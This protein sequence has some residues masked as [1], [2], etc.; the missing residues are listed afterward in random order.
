MSL[1]KE[2]KLKQ[3]YKL[4]PEGVVVPSAWF[5]ANRYSSQ[6]LYKY[7]KNGWLSKV[8]TGAYARSASVLEWQGAILGLQKLVQLPFY[9]GGVTALNIEGYA[10]YLPIGREKSISLYGK[11][12]PPAWVKSLESPIFT[13]HKKP[14]F[15]MLGLKKYDTKIR[16]WQIEISSAERAILELLYE[17]GDK[18]VSFQFTAEIFEGLNTLSPRLLNE[19]LLNC[20]NRKIKR[21]FLFFANYYNFPWVKHLSKEISLGAGKLQI[22]KDGHYNKTYM[23][24]VPKEF[25]A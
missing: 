9:V 14:D 11:E 10:H 16:D 17:V 1:E 18:G 21:L 13:F 12:K 8:G 6:L 15:G 20:S 5:T 23:I 3:L 22:V 7:V 25:N 2:I 24:T 4:L 19:L